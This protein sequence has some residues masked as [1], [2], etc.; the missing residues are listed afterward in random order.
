MIYILLV[1]TL[2]A[3]SVAVFYGLRPLIRTGGYSDGQTVAEPETSVSV[4][5][6]AD[7]LNELLHD[8]I[9]RLMAQDYPGMKVIVV[10]NATAQATVSL[11]EEYSGRYENLYFTFIP[12]GSH[13]LS[14]HKLAYTVGIKAAATDVVITTSSLCEIPSL[15]WI[16]GIMTP[17]N[18]SPDIEVVMGFASP[19]FSSVHSVSR[20]YRQ[21]DFIMTSASWIGYALGG[22]PYRGDGVNL[23]FR[24][25]LFF[26]NN[27]YAASNYIHGG[28]DDLFVS[29]I[30]DEKNSA[31]VL[32]A[33]TRLSMNWG[34]STPRLLSSLKERYKFTSH[35]LNR[36]PV[37]RQQICAL[38]QWLAF[39]L[40][41]AGIVSGITLSSTVELMALRSSVHLLM[42]LGMFGVEIYIYRRAA[43]RLGA[44]KLWWSVPLFMLWRPIGDILFYLRHRS[45]RY[46]NFTWQRR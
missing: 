17:F 20:W 19:D 29:D 3:A 1:L 34:A 40:S 5:V 39:L 10:C 46:R 6:Y 37:V 42:L 35:Y 32:S 45:G 24:R 4:I 25:K 2:I 41:V 26:D 7:S 8:Y 30:A 27:G 14:R 15:K 28:D 9:E 38:M 36:A 43:S 21:F 44:L 22:R 11:S 13:N 18:E 31:V 23:A 33:D 12:P 16:S